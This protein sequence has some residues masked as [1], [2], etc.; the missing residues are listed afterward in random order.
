MLMEKIKNLRSNILSKINCHSIIRAIKLLRL[1]RFSDLKIDSIRQLVLFPFRHKFWFG[2]AV[3]LLAL[4]VFSAAAIYRGYFM[5][6]ANTAQTISK[7]AAMSK[8][9]NSIAS[10][11]PN[12]TL[13]NPSPS[14]NP[15]PTD[16]TVLGTSDDSSSDTS[17]DTTISPPAAASPVPTETPGTNFNSTQVLL[18]TIRVQKIRIVQ[19]AQLL[20]NSWY[21]DLYPISPVSTSNGSATLTVNIRDCTIN[22][23]SSS[24]TVKIS[25]SSGDSNTQVNGQNL[26][27]S[28]TT[29]NG[30]A[31]FTVSSQIT[32]TVDL[33][34]QDTTDS[35]TVTDTNNN[36]PSVVFNGSSITST[37]TE[38]PTPNSTQSISPSPT[39]L[40]TAT[41][42]PNP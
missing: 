21:S 22:N 20:P 28:I 13:D 36:N 27:V 15:S 37:P 3:F 19:R 33:T 32:G 35:F 42:T 7:E 6:S 10:N 9:N 23:V 1:H 29:Q 30:Q 5:T 31:S 14:A 40:P 41:P 24:S 8:T 17:K 16:S 4:I 2:G 26:P 12:P 39:V 18:L 25:L 34:I 11:I 38:T